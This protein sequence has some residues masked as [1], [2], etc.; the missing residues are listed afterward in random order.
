[1]IRINLVIKKADF[2]LLLLLFIYKIIMDGLYVFFITPYYSYMGMDYNSNVI[3]VIVSFLVFFIASFQIIKVYNSKKPSSLIAY[4]INLVYFI[5]GSTFFAF[6]T[7][8]ENYFVFY[9]L[10]WIIFNG[11]YNLIPAI[12][13]GF[14]RFKNQKRVF[15]IILVLIIIGTIYITGRYNGFRLHFGLFNVYELRA[16]VSEIALP[17]ILG[18]FRPI[19]SS[20][21]PIGAIIF[22]KRK[23]YFFF[24]VFVFLQLFLFAFG[25]HKT[26]LFVL[27]VAIVSIIFIKRNHKSKIIYLLMGIN[28]IGICESMLTGGLSNIIAI[29]QRRNMFTTNLISLWYYE[30]FSV[31]GADF[32]RQSFLRHFGFV[33]KYETPIPQMISLLYTGRLGGANNGMIGDAYANFGWLGLLFYPIILVLAFRFFDYCTKGLDINIVF[34]TSVIFAI[35]IINS[36]LFTVMLTHGFVFITLILYL[37]SNRSHQTILKKD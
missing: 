13:F 11:Y 26:T 34:V 12:D 6:S 18:Y 24:S 2:K 32:L 29:F 19:A 36:S 15:Y 33:S 22:L 3:K 9:S 30:Y 7:V 16:A 28:L 27:V 31:N 25:G 10:Y 17:G 23:Q 35:N 4:L 14:I 8:D 5:P 20:L 1:M 21:I 37:I